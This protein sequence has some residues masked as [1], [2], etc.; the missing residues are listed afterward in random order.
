MDIFFS[1]NNRKKV[2]Q[3][4]IVP[5]EFKIQSPF[6]NE[7]YTT[8]SQGDIALIGQRGLKTIA[9]STFFPKKT[10]SFARSKKYK[11][12]EYVELFES[13][14]DKRIPIR[15]VITNTPINML[16]LIDNFEYGPQ[17]GSGDI[18]YSLSLSEFKEI[19]LKTK[20]V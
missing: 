14:R 15:L 3:L 13:W 17:D 2:V 5:S 20:R 9:F 19:K 7:T 10:Y 16:I 18:Y 6:N 1:E 8:I 11:G 12:W 4:P